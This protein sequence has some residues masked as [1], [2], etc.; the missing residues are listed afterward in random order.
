MKSISKTNLFY[1]I[2]A[3]I[4]LT[5]AGLF[6]LSGAKYDSTAGLIL[7]LFYMFIPAIAV[8][9]VEK[10]IY[11]QVIKKK[12]LISFKLNK[13]FI[14]AWLIAPVIAF[15]S[16]GVALLFHDVSFSPA[17]EGMFDRFEDMLTPG[18][19]KEMRESIEN[20]PFHPMCV[21]LIQGLFAGITI[22]AIAG[23]GEE[24]G[25]RGFLV[26]QFEKQFFFKAALIIG[27]V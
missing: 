14:I 1:I 23:F 7:A 10:L 8:L 6:Y 12:L 13:W 22:N 24:L 17:M 26:R 20:M 3:A 21:A 9:I 16:I 11:K 15:A 4:S 18:Q 25:W 2:T 5:A 27:F 19:M